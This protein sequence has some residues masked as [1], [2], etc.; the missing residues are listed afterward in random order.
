MP[1]TEKK[2]LDRVAGFLL[3]GDRST[4]RDTVVITPGKRA[5]QALKK[6]LAAQAQSALW[7]PRMVSIGELHTFL[8]GL[9]PASNAR[10]LCGLYE[11]HRAANPGNADAFESFLHYAPTVLA[12]FN[13]VDLYLI[14]AHKLF[15][16]LRSIKEIEAWSL[17]EPQLTPQQEAYVQ[18]WRRMGALYDAFAAWQDATGTM[19]SGRLARTTAG[20]A[21]ECCTAFAGTRFV[22]AGTHA[23]HAA[24][25]QIQQ[26]FLRNGM[27][28]VL[29]DSDDFYL[30]IPDHEA[31][32][33]F[34][35]NART[36]GWT[37][38]Y[39]RT[40]P[41]QINLHRCNSGI[42]TAALAAKLLK[43]KSPGNVVVVTTGNPDFTVLRQRTPPDLPLR[44]LGVQK[45]AET[46]EFQWVI[47]WCQLR[48]SLESG[49]HRIRFSE[50]MEW[51]SVQS[52][53]GTPAA[54]AVRH[55]LVAQNMFWLNA[56][57]F[58]ELE[59]QFDGL[60]AALQWLRPGP[61]AGPQAMLAAIDRWLVSVSGQ[62]LIPD[63]F[64]DLLR[65]AVAALSEYNQQTPGSLT[66]ASIPVFLQLTLGNESLE[67]GETPPEGIDVM[68]MLETRALDFDHVIVMGAI[69]GQ[70]PTPWNAITFIP[71]EVRALYHLPGRD[72]HEG[73]YA[74]HFYRLLQRAAAV[75]LIYH[76]SNEG[77]GVYEPSRYLLQL[78]T[79][80]TAYAPSTRITQYTWHNEPSSA[81]VVPLA[82]A[83]SEE[84]KLR[85]M[86]HLAEGISPSAYNVWVSCPLDY[87]F[88]HVARLGEQERV[89][90][91]SGA[92]KTGSV[93]H[94]VLEKFYENFKDS[95]P[96]ASDFDA[97][98]AS[99][100]S[101]ITEAFHHF[102]IRHTED[103]INFLTARVVREMLLHYL[104][105]EQSL[106]ASANP[107]RVM[108]L[109]QK[110]SYRLPEALAGAHEMRLSGTADRVQRHDGI[111]QI[112][113]YKTGKVEQS[114]VNFKTDKGIDP[115][116]TEPQYAKL[117]Q[118]LI[119][120][121]IYMRTENLGA[122]QCR[123]YFISFV[124]LASGPVSA[125]VD[126]VPPDDAFM[127]AFEW[128]LSQQLKTL[129]EWNDWK[130]KP[131]NNY[132]QYCGSPADKS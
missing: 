118:I 51:L 26:T 87:Y 86:R 57:A 90:E 96:H 125:L 117:R 30:S 95:F 102:N 112:I 84:I 76:P 42:G 108:A 59:Q 122:A 98:I 22:Y 54:Q 93:V 79:E 126:G 78:E 58:D 107:P 2:F 128:A 105:A 50:F 29:Q 16:D 69:E 74:Y 110:L 21:E 61:E 67:R 24:D 41:K 48:K 43:G 37:G 103:G 56:G 23:L 1:E 11:C 27:A 52:C 13:E 83:G 25:Q 70:L 109:E 31:A 10:L 77:V 85:I 127:D 15:S 75:D 8:T 113:D 132:C 38:E 99:L 65:E 71:W 115:L 91:F 82:A 9:H 12:D 34:S 81:T 88:R 36:H 49:A 101:R 129:V 39:F 106:S 119:Y 68:G 45:I 17:S 46:P 100:S 121:L 97:L 33:H 14:N 92:A 94:H 7:L 40:I 20:R 53:T 64:I 120:Q 6:S 131:E 35:P 80:L 130:H 62:D 63:R 19:S 4:L 73:L 44:Y 116:L 89:E 5:G 28:E 47:R 18:F 60:D 124:R 72:H 123:G 32:F 111:V 3:A 104:R 66:T 114:D 55:Y